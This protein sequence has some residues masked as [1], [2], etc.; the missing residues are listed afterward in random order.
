MASTPGSTN[1]GTPCPEEPFTFPSFGNFGPPYIST[2]SLPR[3]TIGLLV[4][5]FPSSMILNP[6]S[7]SAPPNTSY[8]S[9]PP[10]HQPH[11]KKFPSSPIKYPS[12]SPYSPS[13][14]S[15]ESSQADQKRK[16]QKEKKK[17]KN[18]KPPTTLDVG[19]KQPATVNS[20]RSVDEVNRIKMKNMKPKFPCSLCKGGHLLRDCPGLPKVLEMWSSTSL[21]ST[22]HA[23]DIPSTSDIKVGKKNTTFKFP[24]MLCEGD[25]YSHLFPCMDE[26]S[27]LL[28]NLHLPTSYHNI[29]PN[30]SLVHGMVNPVPSSVSLIDHVVNLVTSLVTPVEKVVSLVT[31]SVNPTPPLKSAKV[32]DLVPPSND[33]TPPLRRDKVVSPVT[34]SVI[35]TPPLKSAKV[36]DLLLPSVDPTPPLRSAKVVSLV[37]S[38][39]NPTPLTSDKVVDLVPPLINHNPPLRSVKLVSLVLPSVNPTLPLKSVKVTD[40]VP[41]LVSPTLHPKS[42]KVLVS[43][44]SSFNPALPLKSSNVV[45]L[46]PSSI[47]PTLP[48]ESKPDYAH[49]FLVDTES[50]ML[51]GIHLSPKK[52]PPSNKAILFDG[53]ALTGP[54]LPSHIPFKVTV[55]VC[56]QVVPQTLID[57]GSY[58]SILS[59]IAWQALGYPQLVLVTQTLFTFNRRTSHPLGILPYFLI[60][61]GGKTFFIDVMVVQDPLDFDLLLGRDYVYSMKVIVSTIFPMI[62]FP[63]DGRMVDIDQ[64][65][66][67]GP[68]LTINPMNSLNGSYM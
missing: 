18:T 3:L 48:L 41:S 34:S 30:L 37:T 65:S 43:V 38:S 27:S 14:I 56:G 54:Q 24:Y 49:V 47:D 39:V 36:V 50:I 58:V 16:K 53:G 63:H 17:P 15:K 62:S 11:V 26:A 46:I 22:I 60:N 25:H 6:P 52:P 12:F 5:L 33:P 13:E 4:W 40:S 32:V 67:I 66:F 7:A 51:G 1:G 64:I 59:S 31:S 2:L 42:A 28:E 10:T 23:G 19:S 20:T 8:F 45:N 44:T 29:S 35:P 68:N 57:E 9:T 21:A 55:Q 61:L